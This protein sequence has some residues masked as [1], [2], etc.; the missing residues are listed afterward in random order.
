[1][2]Q[3]A[4]SLKGSSGYVGAKRLVALSG[5]LEKMGRAGRTEAAASVLAQL[6]AEFERV[7][8]ALVA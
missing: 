7:R 2:T 3:A 6:V 1:L 4:H 5:E 8:Q